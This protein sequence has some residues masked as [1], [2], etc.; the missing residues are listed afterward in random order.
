MCK[1]LLKT[2]IFVTLTMILLMAFLVGV[3]H[4]RRGCCSHHGGVCGC[5]C[6]DGSSLSYKC[7]PYYP[8][9]N[10]RRATP[11]KPK[12]RRVVA[13]PKPKDYQKLGDRAYKRGSYSAAAKNYRKRLEENSSDQDAHFGLAN[14]L[15]RS[16]DLEQAAVHYEKATTSLTTR[17]LANNNLG[18]IRYRHGKITK[19]AEAFSQAATGDE[20]AMFN[21][22]VVK[23]AE[24][25]EGARDTWRAYLNAMKDNKGEMKFRKIAKMRLAIIDEALSPKPVEAVDDK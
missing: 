13:T 14:S 19:A 25:L 16:R 15:F 22:A 23:E 1:K 6:C 24:S 20:R 5:R 17:F 11:P 18:V 9:C 2:T 10:E 7:A 8:S 21:L 4:A 3:A 12:K